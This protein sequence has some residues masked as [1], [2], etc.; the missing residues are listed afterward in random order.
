M[1]KE[2][3]LLEKVKGHIKDND[4]NLLKALIKDIDE[5]NSKYLNGICVMYID[6][7]NVG[8][9]SEFD[10]YETYSIRLHNLSN[11]DNVSDVNVHDHLDIHQLDDCLCAIE[12][13]HEEFEKC[14]GS[15]SYYDKELEEDINS[16]NEEGKITFV[17]ED[18]EIL[19]ETYD[20]F[21]ELPL[22]VQL[23]QLNR[24]K[25]DILSFRNK[26]FT[27]YRQRWINDIALVNLLIYYH[28]KYMSNNKVKIYG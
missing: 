2:K 7:D 26:D 10:P 17:G 12:S 8:N 11:N 25:S 15:L 13:Y 14:I 27:Q 28:S 16:A 1:Y 18:F 22:S 4:I 21:C 6:F 24:L 23:F 9:Y 5:F 19:T 20:K 3:E